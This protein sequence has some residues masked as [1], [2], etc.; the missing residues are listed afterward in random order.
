VFSTDPFKI[1]QLPS[2]DYWLRLKNPF[3]R[4]VKPTTNVVLFTVKQIESH[5]AHPDAKCADFLTR[6]IASAKKWP[7]I[8]DEAQLYELVNTNVAAGSD[9]TGIALRQIIYSFMTHPQVYA[10]FLEELKA[11]L[12][13]RIGV[14]DSERPITWAEGREMKYLQAVI[15]ECL[16]CH[17]ALGEI[18]PRVVPQGGVELCGKFLPAGTIIGCNAW[19][20]HQDRGVFGEDADEFRPERWLDTEERVRRMEALSF[21]FGAGNRICIGRHIALLEMSKFIPEFFRR[22]E[23][24]I[25]DPGRWKTYPGWIVPQTGLDVYVKHRNLDFWRLE[26]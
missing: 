13:N 15:K 16:R 17:P 4:L 3:L 7:E 10:K 14:A 11:V 9:T 25:I 1:G 6:F 21:H 24:D 2:V 12:E 18:L 19:T 20:I 5:K 26:T 8:I 23:V 22:F